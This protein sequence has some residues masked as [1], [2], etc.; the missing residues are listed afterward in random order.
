MPKKKTRVVSSSKFSIMP[1]RDQVLIEPIIKEEKTNSGLYI[2]ETA[3]KPR[4]EQGK[5]VA[6]GPGRINE[7]GE[8]VA[9]GVRKGDRVLFS[10]YGPAE[11]KIDGKEYLIAKEDDILAVLE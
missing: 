10:K 4:P 11:I 5:V 7:K 8:H 1:L 9:M 3:D 6:V 2:P